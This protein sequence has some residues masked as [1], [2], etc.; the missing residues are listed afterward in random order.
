MYVYEGVD[1]T[2]DEE[3]I[4]DNGREGVELLAAKRVQLTRNEI[5]GNDGDG[6]HVGALAEEIT[7]GW[8]PTAS[9]ERVRRALQRD[10]AQLGRGRGGPGDEEPVTV[11]GNQFVDNEGQAVDRSRQVPIAGC[12]RRRR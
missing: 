1:T 5:T 7:I 12:A 3:H 8:G 11:R 10:R 4:D 9:A 6:V 2:I